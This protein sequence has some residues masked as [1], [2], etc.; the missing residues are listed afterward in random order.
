MRQ[1]TVAANAVI[2]FSRPPHVTTLYPTAP[3]LSKLSARSKPQSRLLFV[4]CL[5]P[6]VTLTCP[7]HFQTRAEGRQR[8]TM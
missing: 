8:D 4:P 5:A 6:F 3:S 1:R 7:K 2:V